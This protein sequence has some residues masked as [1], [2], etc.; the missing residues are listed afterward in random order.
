MRATLR[1]AALLAVL[2]L[3]PSTSGAPVDPVTALAPVEVW[4]DGFGDLRGVATD[5]D[6]AVYVADYLA[7]TVTRIGQDRSRATVA[8]GL[9]HPVGVGFDASGRLVIAEERAN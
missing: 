9:D 3:I 6:G 4:A 5:A 8:A 7:G 2:A 1:L